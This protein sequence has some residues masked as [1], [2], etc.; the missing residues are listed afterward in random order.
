MTLSAKMEMST[1]FQCSPWKCRKN[2]ILLLLLFETAAEREV[3]K[4]VLGYS[5]AWTIFIKSE[6]LLL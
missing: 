1:V 6:N 3:V 5:S 2:D 4:F